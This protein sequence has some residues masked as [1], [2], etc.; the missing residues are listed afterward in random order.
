VALSATYAADRIM[1]IRRRLRDRW[2][3]EVCAANRDVAFY[4]GNQAKRP[5]V[6]SVLGVWWPKK[7]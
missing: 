7:G 1:R 4:V 2:L 3:V 5:Q 6:F